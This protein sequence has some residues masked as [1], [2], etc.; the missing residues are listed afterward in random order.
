MTHHK[1]IVELNHVSKKVRKAELV[2]PFSYTLEKGKILA[3]CGGNGAGKSTLI[4][5]ITGLIK[6]TTGTVTID[7]LTIKQ[8]KRAYHE[9]FGYMPDDFQ[10]Q[11]SLTAKETISFYARLKNISEERTLE[12]IEAV[13]LTEHLQK[14]VGKFSKGMRQ[15]LLLAQA[16][17]AE[18]QILI[19]DEP[20]NGLD[21]Y[22]MNQFVVIMKQARACGQTIIF[23]THELHIA[24]QLADEVIFLNEGKV[25]RQGAI[26]SF[27]NVGLQRTFEQ[28]FFA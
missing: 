6:P 18:P 25:I 5:M 16:L 19:L 7:N 20:T 21:P 12:V 9:K 15:R 14:K 26:E 27:A 28:L 17:L 1:P 22:W 11:P 4:R 23:S 24:E 10:F 2:A 8:N 3:L 13:G